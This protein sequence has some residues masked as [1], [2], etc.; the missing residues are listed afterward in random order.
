[1]DKSPFA[2]QP[3]SQRRQK[4]VLNGL[5]GTPV[6]VESNK[7]EAVKSASRVLDIFEFF[8]QF[9]RP[10]RGIDI[11]SHLELPKSSTNGLLK[12][13]V[14]GGYLTFD[15]INKTYFLS[16]RLVGFGNWLSSFYFGPQRLTSMLEEL[17]LKC[18]ECVALSVRNG[19]DMQFV[20]VLPAPGLPFV[21]PEG[22]KWPIVGST[23]GAALLMTL[24]D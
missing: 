12:T 23:I 8:Y 9:R 11:A 7:N 24:D 18:G 16:F 15:P 21:M 13:L 5:T 20:A 4:F 2:D 22:R 6:S 1:M 19:F 10:A 3:T 17:Q 14:D